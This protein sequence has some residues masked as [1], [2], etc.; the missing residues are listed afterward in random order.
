MNAAARRRILAI[1]ALGLSLAACEPTFRDMYD[2]PKQKTATGTPLFAD[3]LATRPPPPDSVPIALGEAAANSSGRAGR[4]A[5]VRLDAADARQSLPAT[6][7]AAELLRG[8]ERFAIFC[9][10]CHGSSGTGDGPVVQ[11][12][13]PAPPSYLEARLRAAP[14]RHFFDV[15]T[16]GYGLMYPYRGRID[17]GDRWAIVAWIRHL[18]NTEGAPLSA[19]ASPT[20]TRP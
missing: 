15:M 5:L 11:R 14:D 17:A 4:A 18:Q 7:D 20:T 8:R 13:F 1:A 6:I 12:G 9:A 2:Q 10:P 16:N 19:A 3:G